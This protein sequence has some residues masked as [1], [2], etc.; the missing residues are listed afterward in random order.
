MKASTIFLSLSFLVAT[1]IALPATNEESIGQ[2]S[3]LEKRQACSAQSCTA[4]CRNK[5][6]SDG[7]CFK[8]GNCQCV[9]DGLPATTCTP[10]SCQ[11]ACTN[12]GSSFGICFAAG[13]CQCPPAWSV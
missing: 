4:A 1:T 11:A 9:N 7:H 12:A 5:Y 8:A 6:G 2:L 13:D 3:K 10:S